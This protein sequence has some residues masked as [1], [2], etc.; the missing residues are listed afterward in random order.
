MARAILQPGV[1]QHRNVMARAAPTLDTKKPGKCWLVGAGPG[2]VDF[3][4]VSTETA[5]YTAQH[6]IKKSIFLQL[7]AVK[8]IQRAEVVVYDDL[9]AQ[10]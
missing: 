10:V 5:L 3:L 7:K 6:I 8:L 2:S 1:L 4:T 9:G